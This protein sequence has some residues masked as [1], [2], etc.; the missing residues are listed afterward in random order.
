MIT[1]FAIVILLLA[2]V[3]FGWKQMKKS[4]D[5][6]D[7]KNEQFNEAQD[8]NYNHRPI[9]NFP[10]F[11]L[12][13]KSWVLLVSAIGMFMLN[14]LFFW[15][16]AGTAYAVQYPWG[17]DKM[18]VTQGLKLKYWGRTIPLSYETSIKD[19]IVL[20]DAEGNPKKDFPENSSGIYNRIAQTWEF[21]DAIKADLA[22]SV[23]TGVSIDD[24]DKFL[25]MADRNRSE[26]KLISGRILPNIDAALKN[27]CK[28]MDAQE[29]ISGKASDFDRYFKDQLE[30]GMYLVEEYYEEEDTMEIIGDSTTVRT[31]GDTKSSKQKRYRIKYDEQGNVLR[32]TTSNT[33]KQY[34]LKIYQAKITSINWERSFDKRLDLQKDQVAQT[35]LE[36]QEAEKEFYRA[37]K[38]IA[39]GEAEKAM[40]RARLEKEQI[41]L[42]I[43]AETEAKVAE[44]NVIVE[45]RQLE[46]EKL[47]AQSVK[48]GADAQYYKNQKLVQAGLTPQER[49]EQQEIMN[50]DTWNAIGKMRFD[51]VYMNGSGG[52]SGESILSSLLGAEVAKGMK[53]KTQ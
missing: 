12:K 16:D 37:K 20:R 3:S 40:E 39:K 38:E 2:G 52:K 33:L 50:R 49:K 26:S 46:V 45:K 27:T 6:Q 34:G 42:T 7:L 35:Q 28:L 24:E 36:K 11:P 1:F 19:I 29:Y 30:N 5:E 31:V 48:V 23:I 22:V 25:K 10:A 14:G 21:S 13:I 44:Q 43:A 9:K 41:K 51:G 53:Q 4:Y 17:G 47:K 15:A 8:N 32:D 18:I